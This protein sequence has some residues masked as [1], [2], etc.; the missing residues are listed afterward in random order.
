QGAELLAAALLHRP[1]GAGR[2]RP[3]QERLEGAA[4]LARRHGLT[5]ARGEHA[6]RR[7][8]PWSAA[9][10]AALPVRRR[11]V[12]GHLLGRRGG[13]P[14]APGAAAVGPGLRRVA[15]LH[16]VRHPLPDRAELEPGPGP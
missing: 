9:L 13:T 16:R 15:R 5:P 7:P 14:G 1:A 10:V 11:P 4:A 2:D 6:R 8:D 12:P 3:D